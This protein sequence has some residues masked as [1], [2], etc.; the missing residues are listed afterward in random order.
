MCCLTN[1]LFALTALALVTLTAPAR[2]GTL[3]LAASE[4]GWVCNLPLLS[5]TGANVTT[6]VANGGFACPE[7]EFGV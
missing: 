6:R 3:N 4:R 1:N 2:A 7:L 5:K